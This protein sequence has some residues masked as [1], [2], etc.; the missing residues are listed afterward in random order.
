MVSVVVPPILRPRMSRARNVGSAEFVIDGNAPM[1]TKTKTRETDFIRP[2]RLRGQ[3]QVG[4]NG[5]ANFFT[6]LDRVLSVHIRRRL[7]WI[8]KI[9]SV[10][11]QNQEIRLPSSPGRQ[12][13]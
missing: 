3:T 6:N 4:A 12:G 5:V 8:S 1:T 13:R 7:S 2:L 10:A 9:D 11:R